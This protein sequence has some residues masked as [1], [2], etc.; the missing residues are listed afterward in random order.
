MRD[1]ILNKK[2]GLGKQKS[3][4]IKVEIVGAFLD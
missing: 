1:D 3:D 2:R 4:G